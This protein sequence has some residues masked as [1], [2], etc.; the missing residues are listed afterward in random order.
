MEYTVH[1]LESLRQLRQDKNLRRSLRRIRLPEAEGIPVKEK[2]L[3]KHYFA[4]GCDTGAYTVYAGIVF[5]LVL[6]WQMPYSS[7]LVWWKIAIGIAIAA[8]A[9][10]G[11]GLL[12]SA[13][14]LR[15]YYRKLEAYFTPPDTRDLMSH[16][17][18]FDV[19]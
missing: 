5:F 10:K 12:I 15:R 18:A 7:L 1:N 11:F 8:L 16:P 17:L 14:K 9:G 13:Y 4:C 3:N 6:W 2:K 19:F